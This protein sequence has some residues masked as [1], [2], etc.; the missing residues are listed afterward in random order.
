FTLSALT[1]YAT[2]TSAVTYNYYFSNLHAHSDYSDGNDDHP[3]YTPADDYN[4]AMT[5]QCMDFLGISEHNHYSSN[6]NAGNTIANY[7]KGPIQADSFT[8]VH[9]NFL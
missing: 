9:P 7:H 2:N 3:G 1:D 5:A 6:D 8:N 4:Y